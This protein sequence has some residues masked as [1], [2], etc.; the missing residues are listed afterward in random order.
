MRAIEH[1]LKTF[2]S[3]TTGKKAVI[4]LGCGYDALPFRLIS[5]S[6]ELCKT[7]TFVDVDYE[8][9]IQEKVTIIRQNTELSGLLKGMDLVDQVKP[10]ML[11]SDNYLAVGCDLSKPGALQDLLAKEF[12]DEVSIFI[13]SE[14]SITYMPVETADALISWMSRLSNGRCGTRSRVREPMKQG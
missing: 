3:E 4:N 10:V 6:A 14:V 9:L 7:A 2:L 11:R 12:G 1:E 5:C 8:S 13:I